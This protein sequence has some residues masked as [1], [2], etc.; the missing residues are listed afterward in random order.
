MGALNTPHAFW[1][2][3]YVAMVKLSFRPVEELRAEAGRPLTT[4]AYFGPSFRGR[5]LQIKPAPPPLSTES[6]VV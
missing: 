4:A 3:T 6:G 2:L 5:G 1:S